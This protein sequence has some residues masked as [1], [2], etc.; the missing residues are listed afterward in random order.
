MYK[1]EIQNVWYLVVLALSHKYL[2][3]GNIE[4]YVPIYVF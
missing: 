1:I 2:V 4:L 3:F